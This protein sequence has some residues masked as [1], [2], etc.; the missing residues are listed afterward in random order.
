MQIDPEWILRVVER[1]LTPILL[2]IALIQGWLV[3]KYV[4]L[5]VLASERELRNIVLRNTELTD[6]AV[7]S[8][9]RI[10]ERTSGTP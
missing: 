7:K 1:G 3:P 2:V 9:E 10:V 5:Q 6:R 8:T 4:Y